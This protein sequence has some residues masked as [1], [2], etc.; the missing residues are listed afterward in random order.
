[1]KKV[2]ILGAVCLALG[3]ASCKTYCP[4]YNY[5]QADTHTKAKA[6][7][8]VTAANQGAERSAK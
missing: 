1:M 5:A 7:V 3:T 8:A 4:A 2:F 6:P